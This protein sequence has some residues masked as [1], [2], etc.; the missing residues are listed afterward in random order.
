LGSIKG[1][2]FI[3][4]L[5]NYKL[6]KKHSAPSSASVMILLAFHY[7]KIFLLKHS[8]ANNRH[9]NSNKDVGGISLDYGS[10]HADP[11]FE[12]FSWSY[13]FQIIQKHSCF[14]FET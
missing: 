2:E 12:S 1:G 13:K 3:D 5:S 10:G 4:Q 7:H 9:L 14:L 6:P 8:D 11:Q